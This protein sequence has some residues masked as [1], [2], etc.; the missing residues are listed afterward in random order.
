MSIYLYTT[1]CN[2]WK[3]YIYP[4]YNLYYNIKNEAIRNDSIKW[5]MDC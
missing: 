3:K 2:I 4:S 5:K 1:L